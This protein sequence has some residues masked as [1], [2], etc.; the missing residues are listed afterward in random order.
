MSKIDKIKE[1]INY[2]KVWLS[3]VIVTNIGLAGWLVEN[4]DKDMTKTLSAFFAIVSHS[5]V[6]LLIHKSITSKIDQLEDL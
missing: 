5:L 1:K 2:L 3:I 4:Y 6:I